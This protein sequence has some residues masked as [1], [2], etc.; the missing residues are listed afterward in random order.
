MCVVGGVVC[1]LMWCVQRRREIKSVVCV[2]LL[3]V[4]AVVCV[5]QV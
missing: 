4:C 2:V 1:V 3:L 5:V